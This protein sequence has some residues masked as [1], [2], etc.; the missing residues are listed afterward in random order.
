MTY[1]SRRS[2]APAGRRRRAPLPQLAAQRY[3]DVDVAIVMESTYPYLKGGVSAVVHDIVTSNQDLTFGILHI[4]WDS[5]QPHEDLYGVPANVRWVRAASTCRCRS[6]SRTSHGSAAESAAN[7]T[8]AAPRTPTPTAFSMPSRRSSPVTRRRCGQLY[9]A[10]M[11]PRT[12]SYPLWALLGTQEFMFASRD[13]LPKLGL[14]LTDTFW[15]LR[16]FFSLA[17][18]VLGEKIPSGGEGLS[19]A[20]DRLRSPARRRGSQRQNK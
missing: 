19:R 4:A 2:Q 14:P 12:R 3:P 6:T 18:A 5:A 9:D 8:G 11:N 1:V 16:E 20:H 17:C 13:R 10:G 15:L 7:A